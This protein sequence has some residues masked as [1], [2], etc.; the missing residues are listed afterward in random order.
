MW[1]S[2]SL[3]LF[4]LSRERESARA[5][6]RERARAL[7]HSLTLF[8]S[9]SLSLSFALTPSPSFPP[10]LA[11]TPNSQAESAFRGGAGITLPNKFTTL[12]VNSLEKSCEGACPRSQA[13]ACQEATRPRPQANKARS[14]TSASKLGWSIAARGRAC[15]CDRCILRRARRASYQ[16]Q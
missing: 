6:E 2:I 1:T 12:P 9:L 5:R 16:V 4:S 10:S 15:A 14:A 8:L 7:S 13:S 11:N 3:S